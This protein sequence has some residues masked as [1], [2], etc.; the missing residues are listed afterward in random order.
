MS[1]LSYPPD[2][3][4]ERVRQSLFSAIA[5]DNVELVGQ[6]FASNSLQA[7][8]ATRALRRASTH[9]AVL[10]CLLMHGADPKAFDRIEW[11]RSA[12]VLRLLVEFGYDIRPTGHLIIQYVPERSSLRPPS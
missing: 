4:N 10:R 8:D 1:S 3:E 11:V 12:E 9:P 7:G 6:L 2:G 5:A